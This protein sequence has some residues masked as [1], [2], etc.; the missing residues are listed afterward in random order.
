MLIVMA[1]IGALWENASHDPSY[2]ATSS[3]PATKAPRVNMLAVTPT[4]HVVVSGFAR[5]M[6]FDLKMDLISSGDLNLVDPS[7]K[8]SG[9]GRWEDPLIVPSERPEKNIQNLY[10]TS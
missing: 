9:N 7:R 6:P 3:L 10:L 2:T 8:S 5:S 1:S 4:L